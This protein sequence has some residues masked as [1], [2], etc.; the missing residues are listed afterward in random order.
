MKSKKVYL[1]G[2]IT[3]LPEKEWKEMFMEASR[4]I[5]NPKFKNRIVLE[6]KPSDDIVSPIDISIQ[7]EKQHKVAYFGRSLPTWE[8]YMKACLRALTHCTHIYMLKNWKESRGAKVEHQM[9]VDLGI[10]IIYQK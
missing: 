5:T 9:A 7:V 8:D 10:E 3:G 4:E 2:A 6:M 1:S